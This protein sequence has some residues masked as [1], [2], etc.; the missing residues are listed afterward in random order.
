MFE[1]GASL[2]VDANRYSV[3]MAEAANVSRVSVNDRQLAIW[4]GSTV[5]F[6][7]SQYGLVT[8]ANLLWRYGLGLLSLKVRVC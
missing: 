4:D 5:Q 2:L 7:S 1:S 3:E 8:V 6:Q